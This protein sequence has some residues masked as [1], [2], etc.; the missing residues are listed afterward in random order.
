MKTLIDKTLATVRN[1]HVPWD[2]VPAVLARRIQTIGRR[3]DRSGL[4]AYAVGGFV[5]DLLLKR[6][7]LDCDIVVEGDGVAFSRRLAEN[8]GLA[9]TV[10]PQFGTASLSY[11]DGMVLDVASA[12]QETYPRPGALPVVARGTIAQDLARRD[13]AVNALAVSIN[14]GSWASLLDCHEGLKDLKERRIR[15][16]HA[17]SFQDDP[18]RVLRAVRFE[19]RFGFRMDKSTLRLVREAIRKE[20]WRTVKPPRYFAEFRKLLRED[21]PYRPLRRLQALGGLRFLDDD[22]VFPAA[23]LTMMER[24]VTL[25]RQDPFYR[26]RDWSL[27]ALACLLSALSLPRRERIARTFQFTSAE[28]AACAWP[29]QKQAILASLHPGMSASQVHRVFKDW[30]EGIIFFIQAQTSAKITHRYAEAFLKKDRRVR[31]EINGHDLSRLGWRSDRDLGRVL[32]ALLAQKIDGCLKTRRDEW[33]AA[34]R[35]A[36]KHNRVDGKETFDG[37]HR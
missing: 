12:R 26:D 18:T 8:L 28:K 3:A 32:E 4:A 35:L 25:L 21:R 5:R 33:R 13:F 20:S 17:R 2:R 37:P 22:F 34:Q 27:T 15:V 7:N 11:P 19:Q 6:E 23:C 9:L 31:L 29:E 24:Q 36:V 16:L 1:V 30:N 10:Y 14:R